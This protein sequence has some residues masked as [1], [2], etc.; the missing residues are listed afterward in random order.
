MPTGN[1]AVRAA[2]E[3]LRAAEDDFD[4]FARAKVATCTLELGRNDS[5]ADPQIG[6]LSLTLYAVLADTIG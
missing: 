6:E 1:P 5:A 2:L 4:L 3:G